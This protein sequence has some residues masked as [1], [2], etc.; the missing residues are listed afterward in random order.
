MGTRQAARQKW[1]RA[2]V[3]DDPRC[4]YCG[5]ETREDADDSASNRATVDDVIPLSKGGRNNASNWALACYRCNGIKGDRNPRPR[6]RLPRGDSDLAKIMA[7]AIEL[8]DRLAAERA[9]RQ[10]LADICTHFQIST[11]A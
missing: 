1:R 5:T 10:K 7:R 2:R 4:D 3:E 9:R 8:A 11:G 6:H